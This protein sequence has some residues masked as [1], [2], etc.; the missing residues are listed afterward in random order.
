MQVFDN[1]EW[2][3]HLIVL[4]HCNHQRAIKVPLCPLFPP[5]QTSE[6]WQRWVGGTLHWSTKWK[7]DEIV[8]LEKSKIWYPENPAN[9]FFFFLI[10][11]SCQVVSD[12]FATPWTA[13]I[14]YPGDFPG[15]N[16]GVGSH[17]L[18]QGIFRTQGWNSHLLNWQADSLPL[19][20][21]GSLNS[22]T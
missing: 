21:Q 12:S 9:V 19:S 11:F 15:K 2:S 6:W 22:V 10:V 5:L 1:T 14:L 4:A 17:F 3:V 8:S 20:H 7:G 18:L 16:T 13:R